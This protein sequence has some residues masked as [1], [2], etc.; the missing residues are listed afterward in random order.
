MTVDQRSYEQF[1]VVIKHD[2]IPEIAAKFNTFVE[3]VKW[4]REAV[5]SI[6]YHDHWIEW[7]CAANG[8]HRSELPFTSGDAV[9]GRILHNRSHDRENKD[10]Q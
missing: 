3:A 7:P 1:V 9:V 4:A 5:P 6:N 8:D 2:D 10:G